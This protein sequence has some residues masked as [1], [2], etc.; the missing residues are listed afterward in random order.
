MKQA[1]W[2]SFQQL[3]LAVN[4]NAAVIGLADCLQFGKRKTAAFAVAAVS[5]KANL[6]TLSWTTEIFEAAAALALD[7]IVHSDWWFIHTI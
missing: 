4:W 2:K 7:L 5:T 6:S 1:Y 3:K